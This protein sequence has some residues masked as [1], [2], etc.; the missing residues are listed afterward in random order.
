MTPPIPARSRPPA[1]VHSSGVWGGRSLPPALSPAADPAGCMNRGAPWL[2][3]AEDAPA[4]R[5]RVREL[6][7][8]GTRSI[9]AG[10]GNI[11][12]LFVRRRRTPSP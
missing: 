5:V 4:H 3:S 8:A 2:R 1:S 9:G 12:R 11:D 10:T 6:H 7:S